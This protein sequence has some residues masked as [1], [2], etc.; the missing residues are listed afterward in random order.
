MWIWIWMIKNQ[1]TLFGCFKID[2]GFGFEKST[3]NFKLLNF[4]DFKLY[5]KSIDLKLWNSNILI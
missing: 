1:S 4:F 2:Q 5:L 3:K